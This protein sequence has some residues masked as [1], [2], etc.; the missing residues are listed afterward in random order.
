MSNGNRMLACCVIGIWTMAF[1]SDLQAEV[2]NVS[3]ENLKKDATHIVTGKVAKI[4]ENSTMS[5]NTNDI[6]GVCE[7]TVTS[8][9]KG[10]G[11]E[12]GKVVKV[13]YW[14]SFWIGNNPPPRSSGHRGVPKKDE[15]VRVYLSKVKGREYDVIFP[16]G[17]EKMTPE[18]K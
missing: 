2:P 12:T 4:T 10:E 11:I 7:I 6:K 9:E 8:V 3:A 13:R 1:T 18:G 15:T 5:G 17:F 14:N 16:N